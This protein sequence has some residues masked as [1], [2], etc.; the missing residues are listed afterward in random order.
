[1]RLLRHTQGKWAGRPLDPAPWQVAHL[2]APVFG[3]CAP[4][5]DGDLQRIIRQVYVDVPRKAGK[6]TIVSGLLLYLSFADRE[7]GA[8]VL[9]VA[10]SKDQAG[11]VFK[12]AKL[13][14][15]HSP[16]LKDAGVKSR[17]YEIQ[18]PGSGSFMKVV[19][20]I[21]D[22]LHGANVHAAGIDELHAHKNGSVV[23][24]VET[25]TVARSQPLVLIITTADDGKPES[26]Y[27]HKRRYA[28][29]VA[30]RT[31][32]DT[33]FFGV[34]F[35]ADPEDDP[36]SPATW[37][38]ANPGYPITPTRSALEAAATRAKNDPADLGSFLRLHLGIRTKQT[39]RYLELPEW[40]RNAGMVDESKLAGKVVYGGLDL[41]S[42][43]DLTSL[44]W[45][46]PDDA[47]GFQVLWRFWAPEDRIA[48]L[49]KRTNRS[50]SAW[51]RQ[52]WLR[53]TSGN[54]TD[55]DF[56]QAQIE[57]DLDTFQVKELGYDP[58]NATDL[59]NR[60]TTAGAPLVEVR[61]G[62]GSL[63]PPLK[64]VKRLL[65]QGTVKV[66]LLR[67]GGNPVARWMVDNLAVAMDPSGNVKP[68]KSTAFDKIDGVS[69]LTTA[70]ARAMH[71]QPPR[72]SAYETDGLM[73]V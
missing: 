24:A 42:T 58:W 43:S 18:H 73:I 63:S 29:Q 30:D 11:H 20:S 70:M 60:L 8:Q 61:Q 26:V 55:Y 47:G 7:P 23:E 49:D 46:F 44:C 33:A 48:D 28:E 34:V 12:P 45:V 31:I 1:M 15:E 35:A 40:D 56:V 41:G 22:L 32:A 10:A 62:Y 14:A 64:E 67:H 50:A 69:A 37:A 4:D 5:D 71:H 68:D 27:A 59:T 72:V 2:I 38:K 25:G 52:G 6:T 51:K 39:T 17:Q 16:A 66:P 54:V 57:K 9:A 3:W 13:L 21:G 65:M 19:A 36:F 53:S